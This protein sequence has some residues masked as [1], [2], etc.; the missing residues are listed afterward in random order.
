MQ[1]QSHEKKPWRVIIFDRA[2]NIDSGVEGLLLIHCRKL[3]GGRFDPHHYDGVSFE[4]SKHLSYLPIFEGFC[5]LT[6]RLRVYDVGGIA[7]VE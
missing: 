1:A 7:P 2:D 3:A 6:L 4:K 5:H